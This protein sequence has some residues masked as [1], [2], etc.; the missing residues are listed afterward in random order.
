MHI[1][2][3]ELANSSFK[4]NTLQNKQQDNQ[5]TTFQNNFT[6]KVAIPT[7]QH[8]QALNKISF[9]SGNN[10]LT[11]DEAID[12][13]NAKRSPMLE[14]DSNGATI[15]YRL[16]S[17]DLEFINYSLSPTLLKLA[18]PIQDKH[19]NTF[20]HYDI[21]EKVIK[22]FAEILG[23]DAPDVFEKLILTQNFSGNTFLHCRNNRTPILM[24]LL[25]N[26]LG[27]RA[28]ETFEKLILAKNDEGKTLLHDNIKNVDFLNSLIKVL[29]N[30]APETFEK[31]FLTQDN[32]GCT[33]LHLADSC[34]ATP[35]EML[36][37]ELGDEAPERFR[38][39]LS[40]KNQRGYT[41]LYLMNCNIHRACKEIYR[42]TPKTYE[43][44][45]SE[46]C[47]SPQ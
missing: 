46:C 9:G 28:P 30:R 18:L 21:D 26:I 17:N 3:I 31:A 35:I 41:P 14:Q 44:L 37:Q 39:I 29:G 15:F 2:K 25:A 42:Q 36:A 34:F 22:K 1:L 43:K 27:D 6:G 12:I 10:P 45:R 23:K 20:L 7:A 11:Y 40:I 16:K 13:E 5:K 19:G 47:T 33:P 38:K 4:P 8:W 24:D 32:E